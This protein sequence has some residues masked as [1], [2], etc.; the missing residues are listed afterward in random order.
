MTKVITVTGMEWGIWELQWPSRKSRKCRF[1]NFTGLLYSTSLLISYQYHQYI[2]SK[3]ASDIA[4]TGNAIDPLYVS[5]TMLA[6]A[7]QIILH[8]LK[9]PYVKIYIRKTIHKVLKLL[10]GL[11]PSQQEDWNISLG[12]VKKS[13]E[14]LEA[15]KE[16]L[17]NPR[18]PLNGSARQSIEDL[19]VQVNVEVPTDLTLSLLPG[20]MNATQE[21]ANAVIPSGVLYSLVYLAEKVTVI[22]IDDEKLAQSVSAKINELLKAYPIAGQVQAV[23]SKDGRVFLDCKADL[24]S[25]CP[26][27]Q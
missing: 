8:G 5:K 1:S 7:V 14:L 19:V 4:T 12:V 26:V 15:L 16:H 21:L 22:H 3:S 25:S 18:M 13:K 23:Y 6:R 20:R 9:P 17:S 10:S 24:L 27:L 11:S 2:M